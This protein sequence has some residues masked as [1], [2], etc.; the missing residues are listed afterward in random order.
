MARHTLLI[1]GGGTT[2]RESC[3]ISQATTIERK[4]REQSSQ[5]LASLSSDEVFE[6]ERYI[7]TSL[8]EKYF[9]LRDKD[10][11]ISELKS[12]LEI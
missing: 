8:K 3:R 4:V 6:C 10:V 9:L 2:G 7:Q 12:A 5:G 11:F 1:L